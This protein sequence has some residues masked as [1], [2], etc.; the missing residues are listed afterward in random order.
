MLYDEFGYRGLLGTARLGVRY[1]FSLRHE[2]QFVLGFGYEM[3]NVLNI[4]ETNGN[5]AY[6]LLAR[7][8]FYASPTLLPNLTL[9]WRVQ[10]FTAS[11]DGQLYR[12]SQLYGFSSIFFGS[13]YAVRIGMGY[14]M[15]RNP[16]ASR[17]ALAR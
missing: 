1:F 12:D 9:A 13:N 4:K 6:V 3:N 15:G 17:L 16:D 10:R 7:N 5:N 2:Q 14:R 11:V 8:A